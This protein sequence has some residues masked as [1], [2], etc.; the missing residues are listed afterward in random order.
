MCGHSRTRGYELDVQ[1]TRRHIKTTVTLSANDMMSVRANGFR[2]NAVVRKLQPLLLIRP[3]LAQIACTQKCIIFLW[4]ERLYFRRCVWFISW[5]FPPADHVDRVAHNGWQEKKCSSY[6]ERLI[7]TAC[8]LYDKSCE[9]IIII[10][11]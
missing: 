6:Y 1:N 10:I 5:F 11:K 3:V 2:Y 4:L 9:K 7:Q 8:G